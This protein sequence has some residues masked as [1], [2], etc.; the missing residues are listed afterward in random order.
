[1]RQIAVDEQRTHVDEDERPCEQTDES[2]HV[3]EREARPAGQLGLSRKQQ[4]ENDGDREQRVGE[5][6]TGALDVPDVVG[7]EDHAAAESS[8]RQA[9]L[10]TTVSPAR[11][12][13][14][15]P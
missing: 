13:P 6:P 5:D 7:G 3:L 15:S 9:W 2:V 4:P 12:R 11:K 8:V 1:E 10:A 14:A